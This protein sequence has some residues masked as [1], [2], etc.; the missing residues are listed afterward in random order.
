MTII[1]TTFYSLKNP[2]NS[3]F[4]SHWIDYILKYI[5]IENIITAFTV[6]LF[7]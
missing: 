7:K 4:P 2:D 6:I 1:F 3:T 5:K